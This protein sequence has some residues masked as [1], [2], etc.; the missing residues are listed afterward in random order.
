M[1]EAPSLTDA[2]PLRLSVVV[3]RVSVTLVTAGALLCTS[4]SKP[5]PLAPVMLTDTLPASV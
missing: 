5:P 1:A 3:S 2:E 4:D